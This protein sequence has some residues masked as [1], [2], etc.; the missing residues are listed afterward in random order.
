L[1]DFKIGDTITDPE[2][3]EPL[4][5]LT[6]EEPTMSMLFTTNTS[7]FFG[8]EGEYVT[9]RHLKNRLDKELEKNLAL[10]VKPT[11]SADSF[12]VYGR[13]IMHL[14]I[15]IETMRREGYEL[16][17]G[18]PQ[19][20]YKTIDGQKHEPLEM[21]TVEVPETE[22]GTVINIVNQRRGELQNMAPQGD[23][24]KL[25]FEI[26]S[27]GIIGLRNQLMT[28]TGGEALMSHRFKKFIPSQGALPHRTSGSLIAS[29]TGTVFSYA[30]HKLQ[31]RGRFFVKPGSEVYKGQV[32]GIHN[33]EEDLEV[34]VTKSKKL[35]NVRAAGSDEQIQIAP[36]LQYSLEDF[37]EYIGP[38]E[39]VEV[40]P[41]SIRVR[42]TYLDKKERKRQQQKSTP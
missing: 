14:S 24:V 17:I 22:N 4:E 25:T 15:L 26:T 30:L 8:Q 2:N 21:L 12:N 36:P 33:Q 37:L 5:G 20:R 9:S 11:D 19:V 42:K 3:P 39:L 6:V 40:T 35:T 29:Q 41:E 13:G 23:R 16:Q 1:E 27:R 32:V 10:D 7:P 34:N 28:Q 38:D 31:D 18:Q